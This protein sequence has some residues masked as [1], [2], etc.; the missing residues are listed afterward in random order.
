MYIKGTVICSTAMC[1]EDIDVEIDS[2][3]TKGS[4]YA[5]DQDGFTFTAKTIRTKT[6][7]YE[8]DVYKCTPGKGCRFKILNIKEIE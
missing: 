2:C 6:H 8:I 3:K 4:I 7:I 5:L 1:K